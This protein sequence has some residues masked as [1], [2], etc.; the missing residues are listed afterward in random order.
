MTLVSQM[1]YL[2]L[3]DL[4]V[5]LVIPVAKSVLGRQKPNA[6]AAILENISSLRIDLVS[7]VT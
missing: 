6:R 1:A 5:L 4:D 7:A 2:W 3:M